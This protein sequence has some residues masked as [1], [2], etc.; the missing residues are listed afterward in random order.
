MKTEDEKIKKTLPSSR[1]GVWMGGVTFF[2]HPARPFPIAMQESVCERTSVSSRFIDNTK[3]KSHC[4]FI[5]RNSTFSCIPRVSSVYAV[6]ALCIWMRVTLCDAIYKL[7]TQKKKKMAIFICSS[8]RRRRMQLT[9]RCSVCRRK[10]SSRV[11]LPQD[12]TDSLLD[13]PMLETLQRRHS[14]VKLGSSS[15]QLSTPGGLNLMPPKGQEIR[16]HSDVSP[17]S[18]KE[19]EKVCNATPVQLLAFPRFIRISKWKLKNKNKI[20]K[21]LQKCTRLEKKVKSNRFTEYPLLERL[22]F[23]ECA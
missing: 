2:S 4:F 11:C 1:C 12:S 5:R 15:T 10:M 13:V 6:C 17:A 23:Y 7:N 3:T 19:L 16:R 14:D 20:E 21:S 9:W 22:T 18:L 8:P